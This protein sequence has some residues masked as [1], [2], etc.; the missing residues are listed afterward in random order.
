MVNHIAWVNAQWEQFLILLVYPANVY[1]IISCTK[2]DVSNVVLCMNGFYKEA[3]GKCASANKS[4][5]EHFLKD[6][7]SRIHKIIKIILNMFN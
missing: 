5:I 7:V 4:H 2:I 6:Y 1:V 3:L